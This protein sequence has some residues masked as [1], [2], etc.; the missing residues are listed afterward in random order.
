VVH[1]ALETNPNVAVAFVE[2]KLKV[3]EADIANKSF[4]S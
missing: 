3:S 1:R 4:P 2:Y